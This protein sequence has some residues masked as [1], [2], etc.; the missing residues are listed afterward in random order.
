[1]SKTINWEKLKITQSELDNIL[2]L[3]LL[4]LHTIYKATK[5][6]KKSSVRA[7]FAGDFSAL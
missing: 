2:D 1:M 7:C 3:D 5:H 6:I 4:Y